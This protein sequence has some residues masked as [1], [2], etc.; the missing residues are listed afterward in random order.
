[1]P[2][3][4]FSSSLDLYPLDVSSTN[5]HTTIVTIKMSLCHIALCPLWGKV[6]SL[7]VENHRTM[8]EARCLGVGVGLERDRK[9]K[10]MP[11]GKPFTC[12]DPRGR[13]VCPQGLACALRGRQGQTLWAEKE[14]NQF[15]APW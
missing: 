15:S 12:K 11:R 5:P 10:G 2:W 6:K 4:I 9:R 14:E 13:A 3:I 1:M 7:V 8:E